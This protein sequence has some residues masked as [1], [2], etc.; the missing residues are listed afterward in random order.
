MKKLLSLVLALALTFSLSSFAFAAEKIRVGASPSPHA[1]ILTAAKAAL[2]EKGYDLEVVEFTDYI[3][4]NTTTE[5]G[6]LDA[7]YF[8]HQPYLDDFNAQNGTH[9]VSAF[10]VHVE[11]MAVFA[12]KGDTLEALKDGATIAV[13][14]DPT[15]EA[16]A[17]L[18]LEK[19]GVLTLKEEA[20]ITATKLDIVE[21]P[22]NVNILEVEAA[23]LPLMLPD[24]EFA[25]INGNYALAAGL[26]P[27]SDSVAIEDG[28]SPYLNVVVVKEGNE[29]A[30]FVLALK[31]VL[32]SD[33]IKTFI[34]EN[35]KGSVIAAF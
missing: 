2:L 11:P 1:E 16:R 8:Q 15:N 26:N 19:Q 35:Y 22:H 3:L 28:S 6:E 24:V 4:P 23:Q 10:G 12:G 18:L 29:N 33:A 17:L 34:D 20:G 32:Q 30:G 31:E 25:V 27:L 7:N 5:S 14:N 9:L 21:N 13:P